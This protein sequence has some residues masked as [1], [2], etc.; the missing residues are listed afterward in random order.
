LTINCKD[1]ELL[2]ALKNGEKSAFE[3]IF[4]RYWGS[5]FD[6]A[7]K[8]L[9]DK[10]QCKD[11][12]Q[13]VFADLWI[14]REKVQIENLSAYLHTA[15]RFQVLKLASRNKISPV[16]IELY[17]SIASSPYHPG[18]EL[19]E[20]ELEGLAQAWI[21]SLPEKRRMIFQL[22]FR[23]NLTTKEIAERLGISQKTVQNQLGTASRDFN[24]Q[25]M[26]S[27]LFLLYL[28]SIMQ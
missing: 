16:F 18:I 11:I 26:G 10:G 8:R 25:L 20:K 17:E 12:I 28:Q 24:D 22:H 19:E 3:E 14:R 15:I 4:N 7:Y 6:A 23:E 9:K 21:D 5:L 27:A 1:T 13:D 2:L